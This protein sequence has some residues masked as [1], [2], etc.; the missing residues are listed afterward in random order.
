MPSTSAVMQ[1]LQWAK[2]QGFRPVPLRPASKASATERYVSEDYKPDFSIWE[3]TDYGIGIVC[4]PKHQGPVD[5]DLDCPEALFFASKFL[6]PTRAVFGRAS[7]P[8]SHYVYRVAENESNKRAFIDPVARSTIVEMRGDGGHQTVFPGSIH[9]GTGELIEWSDVAFPEVSVVENA[10]LESVVKKVAI[11]TLVARHM[12]LEG[13]RNEVVKHIGGLFYYLEWPEDEV[14]ELIQAVME[15]T[16]DDDK[17]RLRTIRATYQKGARGGRITGSHSL[18]SLL[19]DGRAVDK[20]LEWSGSVLSSLLQDYNERFAIVTLRGKFRVAETLAGEIVF[21]Q[22]EDFLN[23]MEPDA[24]ENEEGKKIPKARVWLNDGRR[25]TYKSVD[26]LPGVEDSSPVLNL[27]T[28]WGVQP[29]VASCDA[30]RG[31]LREVIC[32]GDN[33]QEFWL[34]N[35]FANILRDPLH[36]PATCPVLIGK[37]GAGKT[38]LVDYFGRILGR[39]YLVTAQE[40]QVHGKF[41]AHLGETLLLHS[42]EA[43]YAGNKKHADIM[44]HLISDSWSSVERKGVDVMRTRNCMRLILSSNHAHA[45]PAE[46]DDRRYTVFNLNDRKIDDEHIKRVLQE[47]NSDGPAGLAHYLLNEHKYDPL[48]ARKNLKNDALLLMKQL[49]MSPVVAWW[50]EALQAGQMLPDFLQWAAIPDNQDWPQVVSVKALYVA[51]LLYCKEGGHRLPT[52]TQ[53]LVLLSQMTGVKF[54]KRQRRISNPTG[55]GVPREVKSIQEKQYVIHNML[56]LEEAREA[57]DRYFAQKVDWSKVA[58][59]ERKLF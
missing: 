26:F 52:D 34:L 43:L 6:P 28:G 49:N 51:H 37:Q 2:S 31:L 35:W 25:R 42:E 47:V 30:W 48:L 55:D 17:T 53:F 18:R 8:R 16:G 13:Q 59:K 22:K 23:L 45:A 14:L 29:K 38:M 56:G 3:T 5:V 40:E 24:F 57:F 7:K 39:H 1:T 15:Y 19:G 50:Y 27:W 46:I 20:I 4:G 10:K 12:W 54:D 44:K 11:A 58:D 41:N 33:E 21:Y 32:G 9:E 36:K